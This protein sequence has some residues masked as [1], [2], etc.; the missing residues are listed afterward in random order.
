[1]L[2][3]EHKV[4]QEQHPA[5]LLFLKSIYFLR[6]SR[7]TYPSDDITTLRAQIAE[8]YKTQNTHLQTIKSLESGLSSMQQAEGQLKREYHPTLFLSLGTNE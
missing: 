2:R 4:L 1:M 8:L 3:Y 7:L 6:E 5:Q